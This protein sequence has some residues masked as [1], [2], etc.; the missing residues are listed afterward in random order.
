MMTD[1]F[2]VLCDAVYIIMWAII[3]F[4]IAIVISI[5]WVKNLHEHWEEEL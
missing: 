2:Y 3:C 5:F 1:N 4:V